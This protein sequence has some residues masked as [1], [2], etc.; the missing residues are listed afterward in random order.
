MKVLVIILCISSAIFGQVLV[1]SHAKDPPPY[2]HYAA[3]ARFIVHVSDWTAMGT[4][5]TEDI[6]LG[7]PMV[8]I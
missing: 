6:I 8:R 7:F 2:D 5:S 1:S 4:I 3:M